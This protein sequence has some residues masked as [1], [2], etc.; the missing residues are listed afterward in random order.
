MTTNACVSYLLF[1]ISVV[2]TRCTTISHGFYRI[3]AS[4]HD[5]T[6]TQAELFAS[7]ASANIT[8]QDFVLLFFRFLSLFLFHR[9]SSTLILSC[10]NGLFSLRL[11]AVSFSYS[12]LSD[13][14][15]MLI[16][17]YKHS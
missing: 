11:F 16:S 5:S 1:E 9:Y 15:K 3:H 7:F 2:Q 13:F 14:L 12:Y 8:P 17:D 10:F 4:F 6:L